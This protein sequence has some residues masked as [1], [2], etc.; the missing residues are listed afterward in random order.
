M[1]WNPAAFRAELDAFYS[2]GPADISALDAALERRCEAHPEWLP[3]QRKAA[4][5]EVAA[6]LAEPVVFA[7]CP[8]FFELALGRHRREWGFGGLGSWLRRSPEGQAFEQRCAAWKGPYQ[9]LVLF[10]GMA[11]VDLDHHTIGYDNLFREGLNGIAARAEARLQS[12][13]DDAQRA[14][15]EAAIAGCR[16]LV[17]LA[18]RFAQRAR[19]MAASAREAEVRDN[20]L[21]L[22]DSAEAVPGEAPRTYHEG[23]CA[24]LFVR[25]AVGSLEGMAVS[26][27]GMVDRLCGPLLAADLATG[28]LTLDQAYEL[29]SAW[30]AICD[31]KFGSEAFDAAT[32]PGD[33]VETSTTVFI[34]GCDAEGVPVYN[35]VT[36]LILRAYGEL[37]LL[38]PKL[39][40]RFS[41][42]APKA[43]RRAVA[44]FVALGTNALCVYNDEVV[45]AANVAA[46]KALKDCRLYVGGG[47]QENILQNCEIHNRGA[48]FFS[49]PRV[50][51]ATLYPERWTEFC[52][53]E[54]VSLVNGAAATSFDGLYQAFL[55][56]LRTIVGQLVAR[57]N[58]NE[59]DGWQYNPCPLHS[60]TLDD[61]IANARDVVA[62][63]ARYSSGAVDLCGIGT[64]IDSLF[65]LRRVVF[66]EARVPLERM[67]RILADNW[68]DEEPLRQYVLHR[69]G[70][71]GSGDDDAAAF[72]RQAF[73]DVAA[74]SSG[75]PNSRG[76]RYQA[77]LF[78]HRQFMALAP[79][80]TATPDGRRSGEPMSPGM[81]PS[82]LALSDRCDLG[83]VLAAIEPLEL[84]GYPVVAVLDLKLPADSRGEHIEAV[85]E[86]F[87]AVG[88]SVLQ[89]NVV[90]QRVMAEAVEHP[91]LHP[92]LIVRISGYSAY[93]TKLPPSVQAEVMARTQVG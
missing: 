53:S 34:G 29:T 37:R 61:C 51:E 68:A 19:T 92:D 7:H 35:E 69:V 93:F 12:A 52:R 46:G 28:R 49:L 9:G 50:L 40:A 47:C 90:D 56:N 60:A 89:L 27:L 79:W 24:I 45:I 31:A 43:Y 41:P 22:A 18:R 74:A 13:A 63:G 8:F 17:T 71:Y 21:R 75:F 26:T 65:A 42:G 11:D 57:R 62:G 20:L 59:A 80:V 87:L 10:N 33:H 88:G 30:L 91:E 76:G 73:A 86:R 2:Q 23:L 14:F 70:K 85:I 72:A 58:V 67:L 81:G 83:Q 84:E 82:L 78:A 38:N 1:P 64:V 77:S 44:D 32:E 15:L 39:Q 4:L 16:A 66:E 36:Q 55:T 6:N 5:Y 3:W 25:E 48:M 54:A